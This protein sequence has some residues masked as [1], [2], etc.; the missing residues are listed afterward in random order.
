MTRLPLRAM[1]LWLIAPAIACSTLSLKAIAIEDVGVQGHGDAGT[2]GHGEFTKEL[3]PS[4]TVAQAGT[5]NACPPP[6]LSSLTRHKVA[7]GETLDSIANRYNLNPATL[8]HFNPGLRGGTIPAGREIIIPPF[9]GIRVQPPAGATWRDIAAAY[10]VRA[11]VLFE[12]NGCQPQPQQFVFIP[13]GTG[14]S[15]G[16]RAADSYTG[17]RGYPLPSTA[18]IGLN[19]GWHQNP[20]TGQST[21][22]S[23]I[24][25]VADPGTPVL[26][27]EEGTVAFAEMQGNYGNLIVVNHE[28]GRQSRYAHLNSMTVK[29]GQKVGQGE[30]LGTVGS[31]GNPDIDKPHLHFEVRYNSP[32]GWV[33]QD[34]ELHL[35]TRPT[36]Q[37]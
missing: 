15:G 19:Y 14:T 28:G 36:A 3:S 25:L 33:A 30:T 35:P 16:R 4:Y 31:T 34:P 5:E 8:T 37:R 26:S 21:F 13:A 6:V 2:R 23:G 12:A 11:D 10:G 1:L 32:L 7:A 27:V 9:D 18:Q 24:D 29:A 17:F 20:T 22:H